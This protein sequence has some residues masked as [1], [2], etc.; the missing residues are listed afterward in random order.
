MFLVKGL[1]PSKGVTFF[2]PV[3][4]VGAYIYFFLVCDL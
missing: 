4:Y 1:C 2:W 3:L